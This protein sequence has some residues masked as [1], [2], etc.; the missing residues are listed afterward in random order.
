[1][2]NTIQTNYMNMLL[3][4]PTQQLGPQWALDLNNALGV[5]DG[6][7]HTPGNGQQVPSAGL[8]INA[9]LPFNANNATTLR[10][11]RFT[12][13]GSALSLPTDITCVY[14]AG[15]NLFYNNALGQQIQITSGSSI[16]IGSLGTIGGDY[17]Q[18]GV[19]AVVDYF[20]S[21][22]HT[23]YFYQDVNKY[24]PI[25]TGPITISGTTTSANGVT[26][27]APVGLSAP[28]SLTLPSALPGSNS[29][30]TID[31]AGNITTSIPTANGITAANIM[32]GT[33][34]TTEISSTA[35]ILN[36]QLASF[37][38]SISNTGGLSTASGSPTNVPNL[39]ASNFQCSGRALKFSLQGE[40]SGGG[41]Y[42]HATTGT[43]GTGTF[44][45]KVV[46]DASTDIFFVPLIIDSNSTGMYWPLP[47][48]GVY[49][50]ITPGLHT[51]NVQIYVGS[52]GAGYSVEI[53]NAHFVVEEM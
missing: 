52:P 32:P 21:P 24:A 51:F 5:V 47:N 19:P 14:V 41:G 39:V 3:P 9:D 46:L 34:T 30:A 36:T 7:T 16:N 49:T 50:G 43:S 8:N 13:N 27:A 48:F 53:V 22:N 35:G 38:L 1:M 10:S 37:P 26:I 40:V 18:F 29:F 4:V 20:V 45:I 44:F 42:L 28:Y 2:A 33:I 6:H 31:A 17:G 12:N 15:G 11:A 25:A 23:Y